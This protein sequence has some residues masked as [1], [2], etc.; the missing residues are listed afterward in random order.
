MGCTFERS[1]RCEK[2]M[3]WFLRL[4]GSALALV[5]LVAGSL[6]QGRSSSCSAE[7]KQAHGEAEAKR[8]LARGLA[9][10]R[11]HGSQPAETN[12]TGTRSAWSSNRRF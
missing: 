3:K 12:W 7:A 9:A 2:L 1:K 11:L 5:A 8:L 10:L 6:R 4:A